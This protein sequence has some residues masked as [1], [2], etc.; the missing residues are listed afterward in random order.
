MNIFKSNSL[1]ED[2]MNIKGAVVF[3]VLAIIPLAIVNI[4]VARLSFT[5]GSWIFLVNGFIGCLLFVGVNRLTSS[6]YGFSYEVSAK[7]LF[8]I[9]LQIIVACVPAAIIILLIT[10]QTMAI[11]LIFNY[12]IMMGS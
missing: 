1:E 5:V 12:L 10:T 6:L 7:D 3:F 2:Q 4:L 11:T 9:L 8:Y